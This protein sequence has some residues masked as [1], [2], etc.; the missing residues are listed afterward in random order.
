MDQAV[1]IL[2]QKKTG[3]MTV[4]KDV[5]AHPKTKKILQLMKGR[6]G[7][8]IK[9]DGKNYSVPSGQDLEKLNLKE[10]L[11]LLK[12]K[13]SKSAGVKKK[14]ARFIKTKKSRPIRAS[15]AVNQ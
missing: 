15:S 8:Y 4:L 3:K 6:Y 13:K 2:K 14:K 5:G 7:P 9:Y 11:G 1:E 10:A 12:Q